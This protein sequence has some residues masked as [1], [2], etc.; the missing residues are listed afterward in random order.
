[1]FAEHEKPS[2]KHLLVML[3]D[4]DEPEAMLAAF[5]RIAEIKAWRAAR[6]TVSEEDAAPFPFVKRQGPVSVAMAQ[7]C[8]RWSSLAAA[9]DKV[10]SEM[11]RTGLPVAHRVQAMEDDNAL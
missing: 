3:M 7:A 8:K 2:L 11:R 10:E 1:L 9:L 5:K 4:A 6:I